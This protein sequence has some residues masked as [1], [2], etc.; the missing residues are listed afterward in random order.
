MAPG[1]EANSSE[2][3]PY[4]TQLRHTTTK[5]QQQQQQQNDMSHSQTT[6]TASGTISTATTT[7]TIKHH[8]YS[9]Q[10]MMGLNIAGVA[11][12]MLVTVYGLFYV[13]IFLRAY[14]LP[15]ATYSNGTLIFAVVNTANDFF[16]AW[17]LDSAAQRIPRSD[18]IGYVGVL[19]AVMFLAPFFRWTQRGGGM[20]HFVV[21]VSAYDTM[22]SITAI[23]LGSLVTDNHTMNDSERIWFM[24][25]GK[26]LNLLAA[27]VVARIG[28]ALFDTNDLFPFQAYIV[29]LAGVVAL[30][31][32]VAQLLTRYTIIWQWNKWWFPIRFLEPQ[33]RSDEVVFKKQ[34]ENSKLRPRQVLHDFWNHK[35]FWAWIGMEVFFESQVSFCNAFLKTF[36]DRLVYDRGMV[37]REVCDWL[38]SI[39]RPLGLIVGILCYIPIRQ[40][41][42]QKL[43]LLL[44]IFNAS[45]RLI[46][47]GM[48]DHTSTNTIIAFLI[49]YPTLTSAV[50]SSGF[51]LVM[52][53]MVLEMKKRHALEGRWDDPSLAGLF[54]GVNAL[55][56]K[57]AESFLPVLAAHMLGKFDFNVE[58]SEDVQK[59]LFQ[60]LVI[61][62]LVFSIV[63]WASWRRYT[64]TPSKTSQMREELRILQ[65]RRHYHVGEDIL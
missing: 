26:I 10:F 4:Q 49:L 53:D 20:L 59:V 5:L 35:N 60:V 57:P 56:C 21:S 30:L 23:L 40:F 61:P 39:I 1:T 34:S 3:R 2:S 25:S 15:V 8:Q 50:M 31:F 55:F 17:F 42:Y 44:F 46:I 16:G 12:S 47:L 48:T 38:L 24:A 6:T 14:R 52:S 54:M 11:M 58:D 27:F 29:S 32:V 33:K 13:D 51:H 37:S 22:Y 41:G 36:M 19:F 18:M 65:L 28:L 43:Y 7:T 62:P 63:Q 9:S 45:F 64:L